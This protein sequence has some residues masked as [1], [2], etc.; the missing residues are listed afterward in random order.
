MQL[1]QL[2]KSLANTADPPLAE[3]TLSRLVQ[4]SEQAT[5][6]N[7]ARLRNELATS[8][9]LRERLLAVLGASVAL[10]D[11]LVQR[12]ALGAADWEVLGVEQPQVL[13]LPTTSA[14]QLRCAYRRELLRIAAADLTGQLPIMLVAAQ[15]SDL[16]DATVNAAMQM[17]AEPGSKLA[18]LALGKCGA[19]EL[20][21]VS[22]VDV[23]FLTERTEQ[24]MRA[25]TS[26]RGLMRICHEVAWQIDP[27]LRP[28][29]QQGALVRT[30]DS[31]VAYYQRWADSWEFQALLKARWIAGV[32]A[33]SPIAQG[34]L[35]QITP[36]V[37]RAANRPNFVLDAQAMRRRV[38][39]RA[40]RHIGVAAYYDIKLGPGGL[41]DIEFAVQLLQLVHGQGDPALRSAGMVSALAALTD[42]GYIGREDGAALH[43][44]YCFLRIMEHRL[45]LRSLRRTHQLVADPVQ[46][47]WLARSLGY[48][49]V[50]GGQRPGD[51]VEL[52]LADW[53]RHSAQVRQL[54]EKLFYRPLLTAVARLPSD[55]VRLTPDAARHRLA[56]LGFAD[57][58]GALAHVA[59]LSTGVSRRAAIQRALLPVILAELAQAADPDAGLLAYRRVSEQLGRSPWFLRLMRDGGVLALRLAKVLGHSKYIANLLERD[60]HGLNLLASDDDLVPRSRVQLVELLTTATKRMLSEPHLPPAPEPGAVLRRAIAALR[61]RRQH[62]LLRI[63]CADVC[64]MLPSTNVGPALSDLTDAVLGVALEAALVQL[65]ARHCGALPMRLAVIAMGRYGGQESSYASDADVLFVYEPQPGADPGVASAAAQGVAWQLMRLLAERRSGS[66]AGYRCRSSSGRSRWAACGQPRRV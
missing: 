28:E 32:S 50:T 27:G 35:E 19:R 46:L 16:A 63:A 3:R 54:H 51:A 13:A 14:A 17:A 48:H 7:S 53:R 57:P 66:R 38:E 26:A 60:A 1:Q 10:G 64:G 9:P 23:L 52:F 21:Y 22:D 36:L 47:R 58:P 6:K 15:L 4:A 62:E 40:N 42:G 24:T 33:E 5:G 56:T 39:Q 49:R 12:A 61:S 30:L 41:R 29:G 55:A 59:A 8:S 25:T 18:V 2:Q 37:W 65:A 43:D 31:Y 45:Q 44:S 20:N 34:W 11:H